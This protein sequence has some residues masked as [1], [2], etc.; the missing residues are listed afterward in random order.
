MKPPIT[1]FASVNG[2]S[3][4]TSFPLL[5]RIRA[6]S[7]VGLRPPNDTNLPLFVSSSIS[8][9]MASPSEAGGGPDAAKF[10]GPF[11]IIM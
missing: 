9:S 2:P 5:L 4:V 8:L 6:P 1:S 3:V 10:S 11:T 7:D